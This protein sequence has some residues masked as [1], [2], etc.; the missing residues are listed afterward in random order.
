MKYHALWS[1]RSVFNPVF[2]PSV[3]FKVAKNIVT[4][5][6]MCKLCSVILIFFLRFF[7]PHLCALMEFWSSQRQQTHF[8]DKI[9]VTIIKRHIICIENRK[10]RFDRMRNEEENEKYIKCSI[11]TI[12]YGRQFSWSILKSINGRLEIYLFVLLLFDQKNCG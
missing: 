3:T 1:M 10:S 2:I 11:K 6:L 7:S 9:I 8:I 5:T 4:A 12:F